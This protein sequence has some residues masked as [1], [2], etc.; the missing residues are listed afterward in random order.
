M[1]NNDANSQALTDVVNGLVYNGGGVP[2]TLT[3]AGLTGGTTYQLQLLIGDNQ[4]RWEDI[5]LNGDDLGVLK[6]TANTAY[7]VDPTFVAVGGGNDVIS[8]LSYNT[9]LISFWYY[10]SSVVSGIVVTP[11]PEPLSCGLALI[12]S[13][14]LLARRRL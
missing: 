9:D 2:L 8:L 10:E 14:L 7:D 3:L 5:K 1:T 13:I 11:V 12:G 4:G 6:T